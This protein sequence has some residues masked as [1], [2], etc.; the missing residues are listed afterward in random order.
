ME[1]LPEEEPERFQFA[2]EI[3]GNAIPPSFLPAC[4]KGFRE[5]ANSGGRTG[6]PVQVCGGAAAAAAAPPAFTLSAS[7][8]VDGVRSALHAATS[9]EHAW[10]GPRLH[11][12]GN[13]LLGAQGI[14][15][16]LTDGAAHTV[17]SSEMAFKLACQYAFRCG[18]SHLL[19]PQCQVLRLL[20]R[21][22]VSI[23]KTISNR[24]SSSRSCG[25]CRH[26]MPAAGTGVGPLTDQAC[27]KG[28]TVTTAGRPSCA[29][30]RSSWSR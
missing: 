12:M 1:P 22:P 9:G 2:R 16:A 18:C 21:G 24:S 6:H 11:V 23:D 10:A 8:H 30:R 13:H 28:V 5:A 7:W 19:T 20:A 15:V 25:T 29:A 14:R 26:D 27:K 4:E 17:D 3:V